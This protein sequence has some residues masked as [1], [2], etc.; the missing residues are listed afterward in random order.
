MQY[1]TDILRGAFLIISLIELGSKSHR[2]GYTA[3]SLVRLTVTQK[4]SLLL[5]QE[6]VDCAT[7]L[8]GLIG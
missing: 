3:C 1:I 5:F 2:K 4:S 6:R 8:V 7:V